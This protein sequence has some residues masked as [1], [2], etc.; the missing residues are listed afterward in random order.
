MN[1]VRKSLLSFFV[2]VIFFFPVCS[3]A[4]IMSETLDSLRCGDHL[5]QRGETELQVL[6]QCGLPDLSNSYYVGGGTLDKWTYN[7]GPKDFIYVFTFL[8]GELRNIL[9]TERGY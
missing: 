9:Q 7:M 3:V 4:S 1:K 5:A 2:V 6:H 8:N